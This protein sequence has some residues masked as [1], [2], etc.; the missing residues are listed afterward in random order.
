MSPM[1]TIEVLV[2]IAIGQDQ[3]S[4]STIMANGGIILG[5]ED[6][7][8]TCNIKI[9]THIQMINDSDDKRREKH[10]TQ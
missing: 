9:S 6:S 4:G 2:N 1:F 10:E 5:L 8:T 7:F 3:C